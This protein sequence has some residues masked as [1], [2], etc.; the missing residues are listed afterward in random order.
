MPK[1]AACALGAAGRGGLPRDLGGLAGGHLQVSAP[2]GPRSQGSWIGPKYAFFPE[3]AV[4]QAPRAKAWLDRHATPTRRFWNP[5]GPGPEDGDT[6]VCHRGSETHSVPGPVGP[7]R[8]G[9]L[10]RPLC[11]ICFSRV[12]PWGAPT[13]RP[14]VRSPAEGPWSPVPRSPE[15]PVPA[16]L[17]DCRRSP[18]VTLVYDTVLISDGFNLNLF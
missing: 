5:E 15:S 17:G 1:S 11:R 2:L 10:P 18:L 4:C 9:P 13:P 14:R 12:P 16:P 6:A 8:P 7:G 3:G